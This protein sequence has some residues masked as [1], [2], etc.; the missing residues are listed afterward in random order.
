MGRSR[1]VEL[2][3]NLAANGAPIPPSKRGFVIAVSCPGIG[4]DRFNALLN[5]D[6]GLKITA[7]VKYRDDYGEAYET[8][9][10]LAHLRSN[11]MLYCPRNKH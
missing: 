8:D 7:L 3:K 6:S 5:E 10:C 4:Q 11:A 9:F 2:K 1:P